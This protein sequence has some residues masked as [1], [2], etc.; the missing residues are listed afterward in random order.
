MALYECILTQKE[1]MDLD[2]LLTVLSE[3]SICF[4]EGEYDNRSEAEAIV[5][6]VNELIQRSEEIREL[7]Y[8]GAPIPESLLLALVNDL[9]LLADMADALR[10]M[11]YTGTFRLKRR[12]EHMIEVLGEACFEV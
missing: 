8:S 1:L 9:Q 12:A 11:G 5:A 3:L 7:L 4:A 6:A 10:D 2:E